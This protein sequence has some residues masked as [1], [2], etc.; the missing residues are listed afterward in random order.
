MPERIFSSSSSPAS[1]SRPSVR[2]SCRCRRVCVCSFVLLKK[3]NAAAAIE[4]ETSCFIARREAET[5][6]NIGGQGIRKE[7]A[8]P[9]SGQRFNLRTK[10]RHHTRLDYLA[11]QDRTHELRALLGITPA[12][13]MKWSVVVRR[14]PSKFWHIYAH[15]VEKS[16]Y[17][18]PRH[19]KGAVSP[20]ERAIADG[21]DV[22]RRVARA[23]YGIRGK[24]MIKLEEGARPQ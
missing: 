2:P 19:V 23:R 3:I 18:Y 24:G 10:I 22:C 8:K 12:C 21:D 17:P 9:D 13:Q 14:G 5:G 6:A 15:I 7:V 11:C 20:N 16:R 4:T 1:S